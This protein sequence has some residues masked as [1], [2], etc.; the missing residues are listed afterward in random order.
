MQRVL[1]VLPPAALAEADLR[2][3]TRTDEPKGQESRLAKQTRLRHVKCVVS[4]SPHKRNQQCKG[5]SDLKVLSE[6]G[7]DRALLIIARI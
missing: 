4:I 7:E 5:K 1:C 2:L 3:R 6:R